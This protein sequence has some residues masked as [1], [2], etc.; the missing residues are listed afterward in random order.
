M[1]VRKLVL[2]AATVCLGVLT[3]AAL[4]ADELDALRQQLQDQYK[5]ITEMQAKLVQLEQAEASQ[6]E[7]IAAIKPGEMKIPE[8]LKWAE[9]IKLYGD[10]RYRHAMLDEENSGD[11]KDGRTRHQIRA[12]VGL[13]ATVN[14]EFN[15]DFRIA[16]GNDSSPTGANF[17]LG[18]SSSDDD[19]FSDMEA[20]LDRAYLTYKPKAVE[21]LSV[22]AGKMVNPFYQVG[23]NELIWDND[24]NPEGVAAQYNLKFNEQTSMFANAAGFWVAEN[25]EDADISLW[26]L[27]GG[28]THKV[29]ETD[30]LTAGA[31]Y[32][33]Y[34]N[35]DGQE[36]LYFT[37]SGSPT[38]RGNTVNGSKEYIYDYNLFELFTEYGTQV[39]GL[40]LAFFGDYIMN[41][42]DVDNED[43]GWLVGTLLNKCKDPGSWEL[44]YEYRD[45]DTDCT[46][47][48]FNDSDF[49]SWGTDN[50]GHKISL[51]YQLAKNV[52]TGVTYRM[53]E[54]KN[55]TED[56]FNLLQLDMILKF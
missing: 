4:A 54:K 38:S 26:G 49:G 51:Y 6:D 50:K 19:S 18:D 32:F 3:N 17:G 29:N 12:R 15:F 52:Q 30:T 22:L 35:L 25:K 16:T 39:G 28:L 55:A 48:A 44:G 37:S 46:L 33:D 43:T 8:T 23:K 21:G 14:D 20:W 2:L 13:T 7:K 27:Q 42:D 41:T 9:K 11:W 5:A 10:F 34:G 47:A 31:G 45:T 53:G 36:A 1:T 40:P 24:L 56:E